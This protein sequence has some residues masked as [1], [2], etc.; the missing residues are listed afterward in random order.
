MEGLFPQSEKPK[1]EESTEQSPSNTKLELM[2]N[3]VVYDDA[4]VVRE[5]R[6]GLFNSIDLNGRGWV[7]SP[8]LEAA[9]LWTRDHLKREQEGALA[10]D[11]LE[12]T[13]EGTVTGK[14]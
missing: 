2:E 7:T 9:I 14:L 10:S 3:E 4:F 13:Y 1:T 5:S 6:F 8:T 11:L 12:R